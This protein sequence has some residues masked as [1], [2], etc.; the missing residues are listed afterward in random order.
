M[1]NFLGDRVDC[2]DQSPSEMFSSGV[3]M[4]REKGSDFAD[5]GF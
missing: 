5:S 2:S 3:F 1:L 4:K